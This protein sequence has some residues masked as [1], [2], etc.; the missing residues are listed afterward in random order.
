MIWRFPIHGA[1][2]MSSILIGFSITNQPF[3][4]TPIYGNP[5]FEPKKWWIYLHKKTRRIVGLDRRIATDYAS[6]KTC[7]PYMC[8]YTANNMMWLC[9]KIAN[10][11]GKVWKREPMGLWRSNKVM[12]RI[13]CELPKHV[14]HLQITKYHQTSQRSPLNHSQQSLVSAL[15][16]WLGWQHS[17]PFWWHQIIYGSDSAMSQNPGTLA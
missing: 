5:H 6:W 17:H 14:S 2:P 11:N 15:P 10:S 4:D 9:L 16:G 7:W 8:V 12:F 1:T 3:L 13:C